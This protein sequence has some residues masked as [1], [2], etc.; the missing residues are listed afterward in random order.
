MEVCEVRKMKEDA[1]AEISGIISKLI[2]HT[3]T[4][5]YHIEVD[6]LT[7]KTVDEK[8]LVVNMKTKIKLII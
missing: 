7:E 5:F 8:V 4:R 2:D 3:Q 6:V 1:E